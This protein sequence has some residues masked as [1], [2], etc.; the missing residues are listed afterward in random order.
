MENATELLVGCG[1]DRSCIEIKIKDREVGIARDI[2]KE[3]AAGYDAI[4]LRRRGAGAL[5]SLVMGSVANKLL[6][7][8]TD[9]PLIIGGQIWPVKRTFWQLTG[10]TLPGG[11]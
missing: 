8:L 2:I 9:V 6:S 4:M 11:W 10:Q 5:E 3:A 7:K 1:F